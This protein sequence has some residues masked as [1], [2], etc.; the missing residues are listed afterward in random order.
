VVEGAGKTFQ[1]G[2]DQRSLTVTG[3]TNGETYQ[4]TVHAVNKKGD[5]PSRTSNSVKP[6]SEVPDAPTAVTAEAKPDGTVA[7][8]WTAANGQGLAIDRYTVT[9]ISEGGSAPVGD[10]TKTS[11]TV[12]AG[13]LEYGQQYAF[14]VTSVNEHGAGSKPSP[15]SA[16]VVPFTVPDKPLNVDA[17]TDG[18]Q[19]GAIKVAWQ[20]P[21]DNGRAITKYVVTA[22]G[23]S[24]DVTGATTVTLTDL[25]SG[26]NV[27]V[28]V[29]AVNEAGQGE[30][31][32]ATA[33][34]VAKPRITVTGTDPVWNAVT[35]ALNVDKGGASSADCK[36][37]ASGGGGSASGSCSSLKSGSLD[38][39]TAY[40][41]TIEA[42]NVAGSVSAQ[43]KATTADLYGTAA[44]Q[45]QDTT[46]PATSTY[47]DKDRKGR[48]GDEIFSVTNQ[49]DDKQVGWAKPGTK[50]Q[51]YCKKSGDEIDSYIYNSHKKSTWWIRVDYS[52]K[53]YIPWAWLDFPD[54]SATLNAL[55]TC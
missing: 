48:N 17:N 34:T 13:Q 38:P 42:S 33:S 37:T 52:G 23:K 18:G 40:T 45:D 36:L 21:A 39:G 54:D 26:A 5:G 4:F 25:G 29:R 41:F 53:N 11:F 1:V 2:A 49:D 50:L 12:P 51:A 35:V 46:D 27:P 8:T 44:C 16:S 14:T 32:T 43:V 55:Q 7:V 22:A 30:P 3:L 31:A 19:A 47:C 28:E 6:T 10:S 20:A 15:V 24:T 9:A